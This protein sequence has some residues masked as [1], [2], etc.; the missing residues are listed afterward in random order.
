MAGLSTH[1]R[2]VPWHPATKPLGGT[3]ARSGPIG[4]NTA[5]T[6]ADPAGPGDRT[7]APCCAL[8]TGLT[9]LVVTP[10]PD[11]V[12]FTHSSEFSVVSRNPFR[13]KI[14]RLGELNLKAWVLLRRVGAATVDP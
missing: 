4:L 8:L 9:G 14:T 5:P 1:K 3:H 7:A 12:S 13:D 10:K 2:L 11:E 6:G